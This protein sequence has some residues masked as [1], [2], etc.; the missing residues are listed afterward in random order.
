MRLKFVI[1][2]AA[3]LAFV[4]PTAAHAQLALTLDPLGPAPIGSTVTVT[5]TIT[6]TGGSGQS[7]DGTT[8]SLNPSTG[9]AS[10]ASLASI[11]DLFGPM[12]P[13]DL[14]GGANTGDIPLFSFTMDDTVKEASY[15]VYGLNAAGTAIVTDV[16]GTTPVTVAAIPEPGSVGLL[17]GGALGSGLF[18]LRRR[19]K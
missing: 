12:T 4:G 6:N 19:R 11:V 7:V 9:D 3:A 17:V 10:A 14:A 1:A 5:G 18:L 2:A 15:Y 8:P 13:I 16:T